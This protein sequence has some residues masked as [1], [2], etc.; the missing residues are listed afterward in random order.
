MGVEV[1][2]ARP[3]A[4]HG[5]GCA[6]LAPLLASLFLWT[7]SR[8]RA[9]PAAALAGRRPCLVFSG[10]WAAERAR[11]VADDLTRAFDRRGL[12]KVSDDGSPGCEGDS[13]Q[14][15]GQGQ[16]GGEERGGEP[17]APSDRTREQI[18]PSRLVLTAADPAMASVTL[19]LGSRLTGR[20]A[21]SRHLDLR[22]LPLD[23]RSLAV[24]VAADELVRA[25]PSR[26]EGGP[27]ETLAD[28][29]PHAA[30]GAR[31]G[32]PE[33]R[34]GARPRK[35]ARQL[36]AR[37]DD[38]HAGAGARAAK[39]SGAEV[40]DDGSG[41]AAPQQ[42]S[43]ALP[44][45]AAVAQVGSGA[46]EHATSGG[47]P[48]PG[49][50]RGSEDARSTTVNGSGSEATSDA[51]R[52]ADLQADGRG[53]SEPPAQPA[54]WTAAT[55]GALSTS[56]EMDQESITRAGPR[57]PTA[58]VL[59][60]L[61]HYGGGQTHVGPEVTVLMPVAGPWYGG[62]ALGARRGGTVAGESGRIKSSVWGGRLAF[63][64]LLAG[65]DGRRAAVTLDGG[66]RAARIGFTGVANDERAIAT[67]S[68]GW[69]LAAD[70]VMTL[71]VRLSAR[72][73]VVGA[74]SAGLPVR[75]QRAAEGPREVTAAAGLVIGAQLGG[76]LRF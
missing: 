24:V 3:A 51:A 69:L 61:E 38:R 66:L 23:G 27:E 8:A 56:S 13:R 1:R 67:S 73:S 47:E 43:S 49:D 48:R 17:D 18:R 2:A 35:G 64:R 54:A 22:R 76:E 25:D 41:G 34:S 15:D 31:P 9:E 10:N 70:A 72:S 29:P 20:P 63:G 42:G 75:A 36:Q 59:L 50:L 44:R 55:A 7:A 28:G 68:A 62:M 57:A 53:R 6:S 58:R 12:Q 45:P 26:E 74:A 37:D 40:A 71:S 52:A 19:S 32:H 14:V 4:P 39:V 11:Q 21:L 60:A 65:G 46:P 16:G 33:R 30:A 5:R